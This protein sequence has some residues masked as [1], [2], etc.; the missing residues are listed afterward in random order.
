[1]LGINCVSEGEPH[2]N[3]IVFMVD[4]FSKPFY[5]VHNDLLN[6][7]LHLLHKQRF[8]RFIRRRVPLFMDGYRYAGMAVKKRWGIDCCFFEAGHTQ[9]MPV[10]LSELLNEEGARVWWE[11]MNEDRSFSRSLVDEMLDIITLEK[12]IAA[13]VPDRNLSP[14]DIQ[15]FLKTHL[16]WWIRLFEVGLLW[17]GVEN[18]K[19][20]I[21]EEIRIFWRGTDEELN[22]F[23]ETAYKPMRMPLSSVEQRDLLRV[24]SLEGSNFES[25][26][27]QH[28]EKYKYLSLHNIDDEY[29]D[30]EYYRSRVDALRTSEEYQA[31]KE[32][33][34][35][36]DAEMV[37]AD[38]IFAATELPDSIKEK[39]EFVRWF[40]Y[41]RT[42]TID[43][44]ML[45]SGAY[46]AVFRSV[47]KIFGLSIEA[48]LHMTYEEIANSLQ[49]SDLSIPRSVVMDRVENGYAYLVAPHGA[50]L[51]TGEDIDVLQ[52]LVIPAFKKGKL[53][54]LNGQCAY[55][56]KVSGIARVLLDRRN[57]KE[58]QEGEILVT[59]MT[60]P[61]F[62]PA[63]K[64]CVGIITNEG[65]ILCH[66]AIMSRE[67]RK[68]CIIGTKI[69]TDAIRTGQMV[70]LDADTGTVTIE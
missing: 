9:V 27:S 33:L 18:I 29:F 19:E 42:E 63:M 11:K 59:T 13:S 25:A 15:T 66:A 34:D 49:K 35:A 48:V 38:G 51:V 36:A 57:A 31:Q 56:G 53:S 12:R 45:V 61:E 17:F 39:I 24:V 68:P 26:L 62:V 44:M 23:F 60:S 7:D 4:Q 70:T 30:L 37:A 32:L 50:Y 52:E 54:K 6:K 21:D 20:K 40:M 5:E 47:A 28:W 65:G 16:G 69:A 43:H 67:L 64:K 14:Q 2:S 55:R 10:Y 22:H 1:M 58:L 46:K 3:L 41:L 8:N